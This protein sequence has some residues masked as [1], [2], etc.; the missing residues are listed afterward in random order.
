MMNTLTAGRIK[1]TGILTAC[2]LIP[3]AT[4]AQ[5][6]IQCSPVQITGGFLPS[7]QGGTRGRIPIICGLP[8]S[9]NPVLGNSS[10]HD[11]LRKEQIK[12]WSRIID[13]SPPPSKPQAD[14]D[15]IEVADPNT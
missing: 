3:A 1:V 13:R 10:H 5:G 14:S 6:A 12:E 11:R 2:I 4:F 15:V 7:T 9:Q 8:A